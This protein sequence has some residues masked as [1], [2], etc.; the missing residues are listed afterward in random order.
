MSKK[1]ITLICIG[2][3]LSLILGLTATFI[4]LRDGKAPDAYTWD[5]YQNMSS[6][7][8]ER[9]FNRFDSLEDFE[10]WKDSVQ[11]QVTEP[12]FQWNEPGKLP[13]EYSWE[14]YSSLTEEKKEAFFR[15]FESKDAFESWM[16]G[17]KPEE[18][19]PV[20]PAWNEQGKT[21][22]AYTWAEY[23][24]LSPE[25][26]DAFYLWFSSKDAFESWM[27]A[28]KPVQTEP[29]EPSWTT[30]G[31]TPK[32]YTWEEYQALSPE[33]QDAF[34]LWFDSMDAFEVW[35]EAAKP[36]ETVPT[37]SCNKSGKTPDEYSFDEYQT[38]TPEEQDLFYQWF[39]SKDAF[40]AWLDQAM[41]E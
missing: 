32:E 23:Q 16:D 36:K 17:A 29:S 10:A 38:L 19:T 12:D 3:G 21:P 22:D 14:E 39:P 4:L 34:Y 11:P 28:A 40:E 18:T 2:A 9:L 15:W 8:Q 41:N 37:A 5:E 30:P 13:S 27:T 25:Q 35:M 1:Q 31:K 24:A 20:V 33:E 26:Q 6:K 7:E